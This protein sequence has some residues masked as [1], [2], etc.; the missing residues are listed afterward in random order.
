ML[1]PG[2]GDVSPASIQAALQGMETCAMSSE[3]SM[4][5]LEAAG[6]LIQQ[7]CQ[8]G[9]AA[10]G[11]TSFC[12]AANTTLQHHGVPCAALLCI[13]CAWHICFC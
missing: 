13:L 11:W 2:L 5:H 3:A 12:A 10:V 6:E 7:L 1:V 9:P 8:A 4:R